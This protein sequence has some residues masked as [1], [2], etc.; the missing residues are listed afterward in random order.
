MP[1]HSTSKKTSRATKK[2]ASKAAGAKATR[3]KTGGSRTERTAP[4]L[5]DLTPA[6]IRA[7]PRP[8]EGFE[9]HVASL[10]ALYHAHQDELSIKSLDPA[11][12]R[13]SF[14]SYQSLGPL[15]Q[16]AEK[17]LEM[18]SETR[19]LH[20]GKTWLA[21]LE[22]YAKAKAAARTNPEIARGIADFTRFM[23]LGPRKPR[24]TTP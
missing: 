20:G 3:P 13:A 8:R 18:V 7:L 19:V 15:Q 22:I 24:P 12:V 4:A 17:H 6:E 21:L 14:Q 11:A 23:S 2:S 1:T 16:S 10:L 9:P 5:V